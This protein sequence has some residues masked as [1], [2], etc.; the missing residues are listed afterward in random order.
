ME[1]A[2]RIDMIATLLLNE[3]EDVFLNFALALEYAA[4][5]GAAA[6]AEKQYRKVLHLNQNYHPAYYH[7]GKLYEGQGNKSG[8]LEA[9]HEGLKIAGEQKETKAVNE[10]KE[11]IFL[12]EE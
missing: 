5:P 4:E 12:L 11:A 9:Y 8:A 6:K 7:L 2:R 1:R 10:F 3:P